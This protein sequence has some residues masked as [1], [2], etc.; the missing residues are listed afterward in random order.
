[1]DTS[2]PVGSSR[3]ARCAVAT[4]GRGAHTRADVRTGRRSPTHS[5]RQTI[6]PV[7]W[8]VRLRGHA[9]EAGCD[10][11][12][13]NLPPMANFC[14]S[15][16]VYDDRVKSRHRFAPTSGRSHSEHTRE[17]RSS[18]A[19]AV[20][21]R[22]KKI[23]SVHLKCVLCHGWN[24]GETRMVIDRARAKPSAAPRG[25][26]LAVAPGNGTF[27]M[28]RTTIHNALVLLSDLR[29]WIREAVRWASP[30]MRTEPF[31]NSWWVM[32]TL[33]PGSSPRQ[34]IN[35][36]CFEGLIKDAGY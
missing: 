10:S 22:A 25:A 19:W 14:A 16:V 1:M 4:R 34:T 11:C 30:T 26:H 6:A 24:T 31:S 5:T 29:F 20:R 33:R 32:P 12:R 28:C 3:L 8:E 18:L 21:F 17:I 23:S 13:R 27:P 15:R 7:A 36:C 35:E 2:P 9:A